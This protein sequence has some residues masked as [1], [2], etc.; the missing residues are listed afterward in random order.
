KCDVEKRTNAGIYPPR[1]ECL[2]QSMGVA[3]LNKIKPW[4][5]NFAMKSKRE[6]RRTLTKLLKSYQVALSKR[7]PTQNGLLFVHS[8]LSHQ[9][10]QEKRV[11][12]S[13]S[14]NQKIL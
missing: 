12:Y 2:P 11:N 4:D 8:A 7:S 1:S 10:N 6:T 3:L 14:K 5:W 13:S 9:T